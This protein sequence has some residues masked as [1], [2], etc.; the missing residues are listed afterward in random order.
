MLPLQTQ[1]MLSAGSQQQIVIANLTGGLTYEF[2]VCT[3]FDDGVYFNHIIHA[4]PC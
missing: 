1:Y 3:N 4:G 2:K